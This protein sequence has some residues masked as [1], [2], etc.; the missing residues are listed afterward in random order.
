LGTT[1]LGLGRPL[2]RL[3]LFFWGPSPCGQHWL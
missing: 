1:L 2:R 3:H